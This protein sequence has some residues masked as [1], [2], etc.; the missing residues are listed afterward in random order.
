MT[1]GGFRDSGTASRRRTEGRPAILRSRI[2]SLALLATPVAAQAT[3][4]TFQGKSEEQVLNILN[5]IRAEHHLEPIRFS[6]PL[7]SAARAH[8]LDMVKHGRLSHDSSNGERSRV[9]RYLKAAKSKDN[10]GLGIGVLGTP[11]GIIYQWMHNASHRNVILDPAM[12]RVGLGI[13]RG[14]FKG[15]RNATL[16]TADFAT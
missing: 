12:R 16:A 4:V 14:T 15:K 7:R 11:G 1:G 6:A 13:A 3:T 5:D 9:A 8:S 10:I 2:V